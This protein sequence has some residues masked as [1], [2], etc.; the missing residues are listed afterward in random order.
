[1]VPKTETYH[2]SKTIALTDLHAVSLSERLSFQNDTISVDTSGL[3]DDD[4]IGTLSYQ[5]FTED[6]QEIAGATSASLTLTQALVDQDV[7]VEVSYIDG[8]Q[9]SETVQ[10]TSPIRVLNV[11]DVPIGSPTAT[12]SDGIEDTVY[13]LNAADLLIG[14]S[15]IDD[16]ILSVEN[17]TSNVGV[18]INNNDGTFDLVTNFQARPSPIL[19]ALLR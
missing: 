14:F 4:T 11:N 5:W 3:I 16:D 18:I 9:T 7:Y 19:M 2:S 12:L 13:K 15:D 10:S 8:D 1:M 17:L 6:G